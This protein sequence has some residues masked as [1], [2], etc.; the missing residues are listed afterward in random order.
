MRL[1]GYTNPM[2]SF[3]RRLAPNFESRQFRDPGLSGTGLGSLHHTMPHLARLTATRLQSG[4]ALDPVGQIYAASRPNLYNPD[5]LPRRV[6]AALQQIPMRNQAMLAMPGSSAQFPYAEGG[7]APPDPE[8]VMEPED[9][10][11]PEDNHLR[12]VVMEALAALEGEHPDPEEAIA[13][14]IDVFGPRALAD[15]QRMAERRHQRE[16][17]EEEEEG[18]QQPEPEEEEDEEMSARGGLLHG[19]G[20]GQSDEI[21]GVTRSGR[22]VLLSDGEYVIDAPTVAALGDG[23]TDAGARRLD[24]LRHQIRRGAYGNEKQAKPMKKGGAALVVRLK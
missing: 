7:A 17:E 1:S 15:L 11:S 19:P 21:E 20:T 23:S 8:E 22:P 3:E 2:R 5:P 10:Q 6:L 13:H 9:E 4:G 16:E 18:E 24:Q 12:Q 14:F